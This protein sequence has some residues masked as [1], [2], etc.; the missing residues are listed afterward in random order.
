M[1]KQLLQ[2]YLFYRPALAQIKP[3]V[4]FIV[5]REELYN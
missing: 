3:S 4:Y 1:Y 5:L 2:I